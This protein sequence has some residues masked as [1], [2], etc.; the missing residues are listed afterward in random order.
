MVGFRRLFDEAY[1]ARDRAQPAD[2]N[3]ARRRA[4]MAKDGSAHS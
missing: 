4:I 3:V 2:D 1:F